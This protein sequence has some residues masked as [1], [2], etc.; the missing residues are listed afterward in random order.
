MPASSF[1]VSGPNDDPR[2]MMVGGIE[3]PKPAIWIWQ[4]ASVQFRTLQYSVPGASGADAAELVVSVFPRGQIGPVAANLERWRGQFV[5]DDGAPSK[6][7]ARTIEVNGLTVHEIEL[8]GSYRGMVAATMK[9]NQKQLGAIVI[10]PETEVFIRLLGPDETV[11]GA[12]ASWRT[13]IDN[14]RPSGAAGSASGA[15]DAAGSSSGG[16]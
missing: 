5:D 4:P 11:E 14:L 10:A 1:P 9:K 13:L 8:E 2:L 7:E 16:Q 15:N 3:G 12:R 6:A